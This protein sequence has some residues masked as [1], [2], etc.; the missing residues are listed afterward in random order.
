MAEHDDGAVIGTT[1][2]EGSDP[3]C[4]RAVR[5]FTSLYGAEAGN[6]ALKVLPTGGMFV[7]G[8]IAPKLLPFMQEPQ[9]F[10]E[11]FLTKGRMR[12]LLE[13]MRVAVITDTN[14]GLYGARNVAF[15]LTA[16]QRCSAKTNG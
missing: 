15:R 11:S 8:G 4:T 12:P 10:L 9:L 16:T 2:I 1:A 5:I 14:V 3:A 7:A 6:L 13:R